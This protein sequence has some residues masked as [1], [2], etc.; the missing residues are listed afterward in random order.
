MAKIEIE[1]LMPLIIEQELTEGAAL[2]LLHQHGISI[3]NLEYYRIREKYQSKD[4]LS[5]VEKELWNLYN[6][7]GSTTEKITVLEAIAN[8]DL[9]RN[10]AYRKVMKKRRWWNIR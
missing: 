8:L 4:N 5:K 3:S 9:K 6:D 2:N 1:E 7:A 10:T